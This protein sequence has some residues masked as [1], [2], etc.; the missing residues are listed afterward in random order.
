M[1]L[2]LRAP[3]IA[4]KIPPSP[5]GSLDVVSVGSSVDFY[6]FCSQH[7]IIVSYV[8]R[9]IITPSTISEV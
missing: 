3:S 4:G 5:T 1:I 2:N 8:E 6:K 7:S 9:C